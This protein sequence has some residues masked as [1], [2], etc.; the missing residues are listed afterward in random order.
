MPD[1]ES[2]ANLDVPSNK[3]KSSTT[4]AASKKSAKKA[5][6]PK[7]EH[8][9]QPAK[10]TAN[11]SIKS[12]ASKVEATSTTTTAKK[13][14]PTKAANAQSNTHPK[15][16]DMIIE[17]IRTLKERNGS[18]RQAILKYL[19]A[20][21][22]IEDK[23]LPRKLNTAI[24]NAVEKDL[25]KQSKGTGANGSFKLGDSLKKTQAVAAKQ[26]PKEVK[27][28]VN[29]VESKPKKEGQPSKKVS[30]SV[31]SSQKK[32]PAK[33]KAAQKKDE[34][35]VE[36]PAAPAP[37]KPSKTAKKPVEAPK[38]VNVKKPVAKK[39][40]PLK[41]VGDVTMSKANKSIVQKQKR[42]TKVNT[43]PAATTK[44]NDAAPAAKR[45][46]ARK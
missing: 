28:S 18:S 40:K 24:K 13:A 25:L 10:K 34:K 30:A 17:A 42:T 5:A 36:E 46:A 33:K 6:S 1:S 27:K 37:V 38:A 41:K 43:T 22:N 31:A 39:T 4:T 3:A 7:E 16:I 32:E 11:K 2:L 14:S 45:G 29:D 8:E 12:P 23:L 26:Q 20:N 21:F 35:V 19:Q 44:S 15:Y 9:E